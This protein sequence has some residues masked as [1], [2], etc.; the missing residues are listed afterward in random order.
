MKE[1]RFNIDYKKEM[2]CKAVLIKLAML[3]C[4]SGQVRRKQLW[5]IALATK[6]LFAVFNRVE[7]MLY[8]PELRTRYTSLHI[9]VAE[10]FC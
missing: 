2:S 7:R 3:Q 5:L 1:G 9:H 4:L 10:L 6:Y 8:H